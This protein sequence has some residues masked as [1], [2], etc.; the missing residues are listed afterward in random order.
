MK[1]RYSQH[2]RR[3]SPFLA[4][5]F[6][7]LAVLALGAIVMVLWNSILV[8]LVGVKTILWWQALGLFILARILFGGFRFGGPGRHHKRKAAWKNKWQAMSDEERAEFRARWK[9]KC[10]PD[11]SKDDK[12]D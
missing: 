1:H 6:F 2:R 5:L 12:L 7:V 3:W 9:D 11:D 8:P 4:G 10:K